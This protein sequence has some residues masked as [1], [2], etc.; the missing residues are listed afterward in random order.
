M[1]AALAMDVEALPFAH[2]ERFVPYETNFML[3]AQ[4]STP[5]SGKRDD[6][7]VEV[8]FSFKYIL[9][10]CTLNEN[11]DRVCDKYDDLFE[12]SLSYTGEFD[13][14][15]GTRS[16]GPVINRISNPALNLRWK[17]RSIL[18]KLVTL[19]ELGISLE[20]RS[21]GQVVDV[22]KV[23]EDPASATFGQF[24]TQIALDNQDS[25]YFDSLSRGANYINLSTRFSFG[26]DSSMNRYNSKESN[27]DKIILCAN[28]LVSTKIYFSDDSSNITWGKLAG[29]NTSFEDYDIAR[30][31]VSD[32][33]K[34]S[35]FPVTTFEVD[36]TFGKEL[37]KTDSVDVNLIFEINLEVLRIGGWNIPLLFRYHKGPMDRLSDYTNDY[38]SFGIGL[39]FSY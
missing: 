31:K 17:V 38:E 24:L 16:S 22:D 11:D 33:F 15:L 23:D 1:I 14:Y 19:N 10:N 27:C 7:A 30:I 8:G 9:Y 37:G 5:E 34:I 36:Y 28:F 6:R 32:T 12:L 13:F 29:S 25:E 35:K 26:K 3:G 2:M 39:M 4:W 18:N 20:H 21:N